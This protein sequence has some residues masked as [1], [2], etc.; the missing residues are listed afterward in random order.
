MSN[1]R[2][3]ALATVGVTAVAG[4][5]VAASPAM[6]AGGGCI[7]Y[8]RNG[9]NVGSCI[10]APNRVY[11]DI[12]VNTRGSLGT[13]C[14]IDIVIDQYDVNQRLEGQ[15]ASRTDGCYPGHH[16]AISYGHFTN[17]QY[18]TFTAV[19]VNDGFKDGGYSPFA[20]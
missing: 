9:W 11:G 8:I 2:W 14:S 5:L 20:Y 6:A 16:P 1:R 3:T 4:V 12:Y 17:K 10:S 7:D 19:V 13:K 15:V 18:R